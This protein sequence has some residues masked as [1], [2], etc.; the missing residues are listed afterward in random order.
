MAHVLIFVPVT[1]RYF[2]VLLLFIIPQNDNPLKKKIC[3]PAITLQHKFP[4]RSLQFTFPQLLFARE[5]QP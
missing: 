3:A 2:Q 4:R 1:V 5:I